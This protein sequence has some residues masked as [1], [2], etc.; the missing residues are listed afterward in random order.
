VKVKF[1][2]Q[3]SK[4]L[5][6]VSS[7]YIYKSSF[8]SFFAKSIAFSLGFVFQIT[9]ARH[10]GL[11]Q[12][13]FYSYLINLFLLTNTIAIFGFS[14]S[15]KRFIPAYRDSGDQMK[16]RG[17]F[18]LALAS[19]LALSICVG[20]GDYYLLESQSKL[21]GS[22]SLLLII[23][24]VFLTGMVDFQSGS[25]FALKKPF[26]AALSVNATRYIFSLLIIFY[27]LYILKIQLHS[28][29]LIIVTI[30]A[31]SITII[32]QAW[33]IYREIEWSSVFE[34]EFKNWMK[35]S[36]GLLLA[37]S[38]VVIQN[39]IDIQLLGIFR[40]NEEIGVYNAIFRCSQLGE[41]FLKA[42]ASVSMPIISALFASKEPS[43]KIQKNLN[44]IKKITFWPSFLVI[45]FVAVFST[46]ILTLFGKEF[47][48]GQNSL[49][50]L[51]IGQVSISIMGSATMV[52]NMSGNHRISIYIYMAASIFNIILNLILIP[53]HGIFG[54]AISTAIVS[55]FTSVT[56]NYI[57]RRKLNLNTSIINLKF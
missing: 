4:V 6:K 25:L 20:I 27:C 1:S 34:F 51:L 41:F 13:G 28:R 33:N 37:S 24:G 35:V 46:Q 39:R 52:L 31:L 17:F 38:F 48:V 44:M 43:L 15:V 12:Y 55:I 50:L 16:I 23:L 45:V 7:N 2:N 14:S 22:Y 21:F 54:A 18:L 29:E 49:Y 10:M 8:K 36:G 19:I 57:V 56:S 11:D 3:L 47:L 5:K 53:S 26:L 30:V 32:I 42:T 9:L 40:S